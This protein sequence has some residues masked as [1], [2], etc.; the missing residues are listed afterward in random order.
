L[1]S[2]RA[3]RTSFLAAFAMLA[4]CGGSIDGTLDAG[5]G[6][7]SGS[8]AVATIEASVDAS[9]GG[10]VK[11]DAGYPGPHPTVPQVQNYGGPV[12]TT[13][14]VVPIFFQNDTEQAQVEDFLKQLAASTF[15]GEA[16]KEYGAGALSVDKS[17][18]VTDTAPTTIDVAGVESWLAGYLDGTHANWPAIAQNNIY[19]I[20]YPSSTTIQDSNFGTSCVDFG[21]YHYEAKGAGGKGIVYAVMPRC[22]QLG[23]TIKGFDALTSGLSHEL[24]EASSDPLATNPAWSYVDV[25]HMVWNLRPLGEIGDMCAYE[26]QSYQRLIGS[27]MVQRPWSN[28]SA[29]AGHDPC[30][31]VLS[32][33]YFNA[34][35]ILTDTITLD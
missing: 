14:N 12:L 35:P 23:Q 33:P 10:V 24:I 13:P 16:T 26:P 1:L 20:F 9:D 2:L 6:D 29:L 34:A 28:A 8:D 15:W 5:P 4:A 3:M 25:D 17:I 22:A 11:T 18:V 21:G 19:T 7:D 32:D 30:V 31:P 27:Y